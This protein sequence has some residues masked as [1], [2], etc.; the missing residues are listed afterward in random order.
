L[1]VVTD[2]WKYI[3]ATRPELYDLSEDPEEAN[4][5][6]EQQPNRARILQDRLKQILEKSVRED[7]SGSKTALDKEDRNRLESLGYLAD[8]SIKEDFEFDQS[9]EDPKDLIDLHMRISKSLGLNNMG[10]ALAGQGKLDEAAV[11]FFEAL[12]IDPDFEKAHNNL[13][14]VFFLRDKLDKALAHY[15]EAIRINSDFAEAHNG[16]GVVLANQG[17]TEEAIKHFSE[18]L[19][20]DPA[21]KDARNNLKKVSALQRK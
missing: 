14:N 19:H 3:Q 12:Q 5:L 10:K 9:K 4:N 17:R 20:I 2:R 7:D 15:S 13:G 16:M 11:H 18:A 6:I 1:G 21:Y 8:T